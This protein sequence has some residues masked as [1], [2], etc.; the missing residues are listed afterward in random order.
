M[1]SG[2]NANLTLPNPGSAGS[3]GANKNI[4][5]NV[6][7]ANVNN[8]TSPKANGTYAVGTAIDITVQF[9]RLVNV[10]GSPHLPLNSGGTAPDDQPYWIHVVAEDANGQ[11]IT[12]LHSLVTTISGVDLTYGEP[13]LTTPA[14]IFAYSDIKRLMRQ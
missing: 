14:G 9:N 6:V 2:Q 5:I 12:P 10:T 13:A 4:V 8:V 1:S 7:Q 11:T 3:L